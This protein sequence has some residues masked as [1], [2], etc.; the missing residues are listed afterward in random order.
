[1]SYLLYMIIHNLSSHIVLYLIRPSEQTIAN[2][3]LSW[4]GFYRGDLELLQDTMFDMLGL[5]FHYLC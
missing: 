2:V 1:M 4:V 5:V 3:Q